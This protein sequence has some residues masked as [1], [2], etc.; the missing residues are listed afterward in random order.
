MARR[1]ATNAGMDLDLDYPA[2]SD[3]RR[4]ARR[5]IPHFAFEYLDSGTGA[6]LQVSRNRAALDAVQ[7]LPDILP[8]KVAPDFTT[9]FMGS[10]Y[11]RPFGIA[12]LGMSGLMW[13]GA[14]AILASYAP[15]A[16]IPYAPSSVC[17]LYTSPSP[18][19]RTRT[20]IPPSA[21][22]KNRY[23]RPCPNAIGAF[24]FSTPR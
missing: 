12:P 20:R 6:E 8:G 9:R 24:R 13:P 18:R 4:K 7:F 17:L 10:D 21:S 3:L 16:R 1:T 11:A 19:D 23:C 22:Q 15:K 2:V 14:E 5:R